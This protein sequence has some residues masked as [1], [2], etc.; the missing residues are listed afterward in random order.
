MATTTINVTTTTPD[1][2]AVTD[3]GNITTNDIVLDNSA[4]ELDNHSKLKKRIY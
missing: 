1:L 3:V 4:I 2:Q